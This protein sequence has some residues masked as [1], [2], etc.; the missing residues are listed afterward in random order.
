MLT[1]VVRDYPPR[2]GG[3]ISLSLRQARLALQEQ[4]RKFKSRVKQMRTSRN[5]VRSQSTV[6]PS[7]DNPSFALINA[8][9]TSLGVTLNGAVGWEYC[10]GISTFLRALRTRSKYSRG[11]K[12]EHVPC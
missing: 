5:R 11:C 8:S 2:T 4:S 9:M 10:L 12:P 7:G 6:M 3:I 1:T